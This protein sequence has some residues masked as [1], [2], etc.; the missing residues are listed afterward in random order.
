MD[1]SLTESELKQ[2]IEGATEFMAD[3]KIWF[4]RMEE[5][6]STKSLVSPISLLRMMR[7]RYFDTLSISIS[8][9]KEAT[10]SNHKRN[11]LVI[12]P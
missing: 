11:I 5:L 3:K 10:N 7:E 12:S 9:L 2:F 8:D 1:S 6:N 4:A